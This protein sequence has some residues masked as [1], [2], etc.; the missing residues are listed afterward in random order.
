[1]SDANYKVEFI[2]NG[3]KNLVTYDKWGK[4]QVK[5]VAVAI[6]KLPKRSKLPV[7]KN[8]RDSG[9]QKLCRSQ[10]LTEVVSII[11]V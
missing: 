3:Y 4:W 11:L 8:F 7:T 5:E 2:L 6:P 9:Q 10:H 1:M